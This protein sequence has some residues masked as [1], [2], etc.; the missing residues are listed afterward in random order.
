MRGAG[1]FARH[2]AGADR[3]LGRADGA[4]DLAVGRLLDAAQ[5]RAALDTGDVA[6][7]GRESWELA[8][9]LVYTKA[10]DRDPCNGAEAPK[11]IVW[12]ND[13]IET[14]L[15]ALRQRISQAGLRL[16]RLLDGALSK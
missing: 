13:D 2:H 14:S 7:W 4:E 8:R 3:V 6:D 12:S 15:P 5:D 11:A 16:A 1:A 9:G 10:F